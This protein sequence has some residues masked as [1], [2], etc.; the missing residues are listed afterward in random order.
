MVFFKK[1]GQKRAFLGVGQGRNGQVQ[2][3][4]PALRLCREVSLHFLGLICP[5]KSPRLGASAN[6]L[7][8]G[9]YQDTVSYTHLKLTTTPNE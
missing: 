9:G 1:K 5:Q 8:E 3:N 2:E 7:F 4:F 6:L